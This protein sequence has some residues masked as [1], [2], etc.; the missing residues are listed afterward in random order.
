[1]IWNHEKNGSLMP[2]D[3]FENAKQTVWWKCEKEHEWQAAIYHRTGKDKTGFPVCS[4]RKLLN[5]N[6]GFS[7][8][9]LLNYG[10]FSLRQENSQQICIRKGA[11]NLAEIQHQN[12]HGNQPFGRFASAQIGI[13]ERRQTAACLVELV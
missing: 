9:C 1:M 11:L 12:G 5:P 7:Y 6:V 8:E 3:V 10:P 4:N 2:A 13:K